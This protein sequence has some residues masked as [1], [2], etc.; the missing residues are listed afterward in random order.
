MIDTSS[1]SGRW[2]V[3]RSVTEPDTLALLA[4]SLAG[5]T[6]TWRRNQ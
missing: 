6:V 2:E 1:F 4:L 5:F 3:V